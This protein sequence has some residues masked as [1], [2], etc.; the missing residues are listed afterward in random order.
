MTDEIDAVSDHS[1]ECLPVIESD[2]N[3]AYATPVPRGGIPI[4]SDTEASAYEDDPH[5]YVNLSAIETKRLCDD[6]DRRPQ[7]P[8]PGENDV[9]IRVLPSGWQE[10][11]SPGGRTY[12]YNPE[13]KYGQWK[14]P[15][16]KQC[17]ITNRQELVKQD[18]CSDAES[19]KDDASKES[20]TQQVT[21]FP[22]EPVAEAVSSK[23][24]DVEQKTS[25][26][27][28][29]ECISGVNGH[30]PSTVMTNSVDSGF[31]RNFLMYT[32]SAFG[33][34]KPSSESMTESA[35]TIDGS[36]IESGANSH[37]DNM[38]FHRNFAPTAIKKG[39][40]EKMKISEGGVKVKRREW[41]SAYAYLASG[42]LLFYKDQKRAEK[43]GKHYPA[44]TD[45]CDLRGAK[46][47][48]VDP[49]VAKDKRRRQIIDLTMSNNTE[50]WFSSPGNDSE[51][52][53][54]FEVLNQVIKT[55]PFTKAYPSPFLPGVDNGFI[56]R[57]PS[58]PNQSPAFNLKT[59]QLRNSQKSKTKQSFKE[60]IETES[61]PTRE[62]IIERLLKFFRYRPS[63][64]QL[65]ER[66]IYRRKFF[67]FIFHE[68]DLAEPIFGSTLIA[69]CQHDRT[70]VP[71]FIAEITK[72]IEQKGLQVDGIY[73]VGGNLSSIQKIRCQVD[74]DK[75]DIL[76][77]EDDIHVLTGALKLFFRE[78]SEPIFPIALNK[79]FM[80][81]MRI[82]NSKNKIKPVDD[83]LGKLHP[84][85]RET[86][87][88]L[89]E[90]LLR[91]AEKSDKNRM[92]IHSLA[93][94]FGPA[95]FSTEDKSAKNANTVDKKT[96]K[97]NRKGSGSNEAESIASEPNQ[98]LA[99]KMI[100]FGQIVEFLL[101]EFNKFTSFLPTLPQD[102]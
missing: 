28:I 21:T 52:E 53:Q 55:L 96:V 17:V 59:T 44:P 68:L 56:Q 89:L 46:L 49:N 23:S 43:C 32:N 16:G 2:T 39:N 35:I 73:R 74:Q 97:K 84:V 5:V 54:W 66:G 12:Y 34:K 90:H 92:T 40:L 99:Y 42:H 26:E 4:A 91:V 27:S 88:V 10:F 70:N 81:T 8:D 76:W 78:L 29:F 6:I 100:V 67:F 47:S 82:T 36:Q 93:I 13:L 72:V 58:D 7:P 101:K 24:S 102:N 38:F 33:M 57:R 41:N 11:Q 86:L 71:K 19:A 62:S 30:K 50:Y 20:Q 87:R 80:A 85:H 94:M 75:Y 1:L 77:K 51:V 79:E 25:L 69:I 48:F 65:R 61:G 63:V 14:P 45:V 22:V 3:S 98:I 18:S 64:E 15:R 60:N 95:L 9:P 37:E 31:T 83:L